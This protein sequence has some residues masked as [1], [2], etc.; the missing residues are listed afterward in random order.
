MMDWRTGRNRL[1]EN[2]EQGLAIVEGIPD[3][4]KSTTGGCLM[5]GKY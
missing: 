1:A 3:A 2:L 5:M 4:R